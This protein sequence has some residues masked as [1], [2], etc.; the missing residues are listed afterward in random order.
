MR[1]VVSLSWS[2]NYQITTE[3][4]AISRK[5]VKNVECRDKFIQYPRAVNI[6]TNTPLIA[7]INTEKAGMTKNSLIID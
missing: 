7:V 4:P 6:F 5:Y 2:S 3:S 1:V